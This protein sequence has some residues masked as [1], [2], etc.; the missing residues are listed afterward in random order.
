MIID[1]ADITDITYIIST[2]TPVIFSYYE[3]GHFDK[4]SLQA[5]GALLCRHLCVCACENYHFYNM[6]LSTL[7]ASGALRESG[8]LSRQSLSKDESFR[9]ESCL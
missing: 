7:Q 6:N 1:I 3:N 4:L 8:R 2:T 5:S 9:Y